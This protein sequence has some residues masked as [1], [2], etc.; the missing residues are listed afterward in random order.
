MGGDLAFGDRPG[1][2]AQ[3]LK[4]TIYYVA[5]YAGAMSDDD[6]VHN[7]ALLEGSDDTP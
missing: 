5:I 1:S 6:I 4:G 3:S 7:A 2:T